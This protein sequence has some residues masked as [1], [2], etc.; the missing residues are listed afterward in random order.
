MD[1]RV[2][3][4]AAGACHQVGHWRWAAWA[5]EKL[6]QSRGQGP[7]ADDISLNLALATCKEGRKWQQALELLWLHGERLTGLQGYDD[8]AVGSVVKALGPRWALA[9]SLLELT[10]LPGTAARGATVASCAQA[11]RWAHALALM[12]GETD[13]VSLSTVVASCVQ[14]SEWRRAFVLV[15]RSANAHRLD[16]VMWSSL[17]SACEHGSA[18]EQALNFFGHMCHVTKLQPNVAVF[19]TILRSC[20]ASHRWKEVVQLS[21]SMKDYLVLPSAVCTSTVLATLTAAG[22]AKDTP[23]LSPSIR[24]WALETVALLS[25]FCTSVGMLPFILTVLNRDYPYEGLV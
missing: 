24:P 20:R 7:S 5:L 19:G 16:G 6:W 15:E 22:H 8:F 2:C 9:L 18:W 12:T 11:R 10:A 3:G 17:L 1:T 14:C 25:S 23:R 13:M 21:A 4:A